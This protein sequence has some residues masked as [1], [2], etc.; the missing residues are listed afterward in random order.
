MLSICL[1]LSISLTQTENLDTTFIFF[2]SFMPSENESLVY[3]SIFTIPV[4]SYHSKKQY[5]PTCANPESKPIP[6]PLH[7]IILSA[8]SKLPSLLFNSSYICSRDL[9]H[10][11]HSQ[12]IPVMKMF[13]APSNYNLT[14]P[15][16]RDSLS[17]SHGFGR[18]FFLTHI[19]KLAH[20]ALIILFYYY[21]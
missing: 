12:L 10:E 16:K 17:N 19:T 1:V 3:I 20:S 21:L 11:P 18:Y 4:K 5:E 7:R 15:C 13:S 2:S 8:S 14:L 9:G 6:Q